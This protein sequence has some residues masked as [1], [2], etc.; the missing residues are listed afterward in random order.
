MS[1]EPLAVGVCSWSLQVKS[2]PELERLLARLVTDVVQVARGDQQH[3]SWAEGDAM[4][5]AATSAGFRMT[6]AM[7]GSPGEDYA[8][9]QTIHKAGGFV[10]FFKQKTAYE[11]TV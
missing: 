6:G 9:P 10:F 11:L 1:L 4:P 3:A 2:V 8:T 7:L 5:R